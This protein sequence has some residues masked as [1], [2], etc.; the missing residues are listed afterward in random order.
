MKKI[1]LSSLIRLPAIALFALFTACETEQADPRD[2]YLGSYRVE[3]RCGNL[4]DRY[5][6][7]ITKDVNSS[8]LRIANIFN[9]GRITK[10]DIL[11]DGQIRVSDTY[12]P[13]DY[14]EC[15]LEITNTY[16]QVNDGLLNMSFSIR[17]D[18]F[19]NKCEKTTLLNCVIVA[20]K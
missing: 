4:E 5:I 3:E 20:S 18:G 15:Y 9:A 14:Q 13:E 16:M 8:A 17:S 1:R 10:A 2:K 7:E 6:I 19:S 12:L 11:N